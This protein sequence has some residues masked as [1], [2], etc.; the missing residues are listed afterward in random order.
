MLFFDE[1]EDL[2]EEK[3]GVGIAHAIVFVGAVVAGFGGF[4]IEG[5]DDAGVDEDADGDGHFLGG[6]EVVEDDV[7][8]GAA[9][10]VAEAHAVLEDHEC[11]GGRAIVLGGDVDGVV[12]LGAGED[13]RGGEFPPDDLPLR[14]AFLADGFGRGGV[15]VVL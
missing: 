3:A 6:D 11:G 12:A 1:G 10:V 13:F 9:V 5:R 7:G 14:N 2:A 4:A 8:A 15:F